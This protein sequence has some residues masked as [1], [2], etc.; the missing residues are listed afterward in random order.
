[1]IYAKLPDAPGAKPHRLPF[2]LAMEEY[3]ARNFLGE[4]FFMWQ[5]EPTVIVG[6]NQQMLSEVDVDF[7]RSRGIDICR[8]KSGGG[9]VYADRSNIMFSHITTCSEVA[10]TFT[11]FTERVAAMLRGLGIAEAHTTGRNDILIGDRKVSG[12]AFYHINLTDRLT[13]TTES[14]AIVH[15]TMLYDADLP[16]MT[17]ALTP[18]G[19]KLEAKGVKSVRSRVTTVREHSAVSLREFMDTARGELC[20]STLELNAGDVEAIERIAEPYYDPAWVQ[21]ARHTGPRR[22]RRVEGV[23][24]FEVALKSTPDPVPCIGGIDIAGD[25]FL[26]GDI[27][28]GLLSHLHG[29]ELTREALMRRLGAINIGKVIPNLRPEELA[30]IILDAAGVAEPVQAGR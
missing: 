4:Y 9:C 20:R 16:T 22:C 19:A 24:E 28:R 1:M 11:A 10:S 2:Y 12:Y 26:L 14:R 18:S 6:R 3:L 23:G 17:S 13:H 21:G 7:C 30:D 27:D 8:R 5:V 15:G 25:F 29:C